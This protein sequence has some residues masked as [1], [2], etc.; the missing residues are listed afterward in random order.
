MAF[1]DALDAINVHAAAAA[2]AAGGTAFTDVKVGLPVAKGRCVRVYSGGDVPS[3][4]FGPGSLNSQHVARLVTIE[5]L[6]PLPETAAGEHRRIQGQ[7][8]DFA[9]EFRGR[10]LLDYQLGGACVA[11][12]FAADAPTSVEVIANTKYVMQM[13]EIGLDVGDYIYAP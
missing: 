13:F 5:A 1:L 12:A 10:V 8:G 2:I 9:H 6:W 11:L 4:Y 7:M 3:A